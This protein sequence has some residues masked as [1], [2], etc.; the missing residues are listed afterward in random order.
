MNAPTLPSC[1][2]ALQPA[3]E[4][5]PV[6]ILIHPGGFPV[7]HYQ[8]LAKQLAGWGVDLIEIPLC[9]PYWRISE[10]N[11]TD[12]RA[13]DIVQHIISVEQEAYG[14]DRPLTLGGWSL[15]GV[16]AHACACL[17]PD[18]SRIERIIL[19]DSIAPS[20]ATHSSASGSRG[21]R[22]RVLQWFTDYFNALK[23]CN[24][25]LPWLAHWLPEEM[26]LRSLYQQAL[27]QGALDKSVSIHGFL[28]VLSSYT[29]GLVRNGE[30]VSGLPM[31]RYAGRAQLIRA[32]RGLPGTERHQ[33]LGWLELVSDLSI[34][35]VDGNHYTLLSESRPSQELA[36]NIVGC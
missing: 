14:Q 28:K 9:P 16:F 27:K 21:S 23:Q 8:S 32:R 11:E 26:L 34:S 12:Q 29:E 19:I 35:T 6:M 31:K 7:R 22:R 36:R 18:P 1:R 3:S 17:W 20:L 2:R 33:D 30:L 13:L 24:L 4:S 5:D 10:G 15:G 25:S